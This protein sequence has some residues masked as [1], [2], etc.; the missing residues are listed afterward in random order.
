[1]AF[2]CNSPP[3]FVEWYVAGQSEFLK[4]QRFTSIE[5]AIRKYWNIKQTG[6]LVVNLYMLVSDVRVDLAHYEPL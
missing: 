2:C 4:R 1:M 6:Y 3:I 5:N